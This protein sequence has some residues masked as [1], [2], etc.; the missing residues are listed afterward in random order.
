MN[1]MQKVSLLKICISLA[2][3]PLAGRNRNIEFQRLTQTKGSESLEKSKIFLFIRELSSD[4][5]PVAGGNS[6]MLFCANHQNSLPLAGK[7]QFP[8]Q[9]RSI[10]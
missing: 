5:P 10:R 2:P 8:H 9:L 4:P 1:E 3:P 7:N 6:G